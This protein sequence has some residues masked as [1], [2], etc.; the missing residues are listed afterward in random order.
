MTGLLRHA[1][2][3]LKPLEHNAQHKFAARSAL[4]HYASGA[5]YTLIPKNGCTSLRYSLALANGAIDGPEHFAWVHQNNQTFAASLADLARANYSF[6]ILR[7][8]YRRLVSAFLDKIVSKSP[9]AW[10]LRAEDSDRWEIDDFSF[11]RFIELLERPSLRLLN[12]HWR[13]QADF[14]VFEDYSDWYCLENFAEAA[15]GIEAKCGLKVHDARRLTGHG[16]DALQMLAEGSFADTTVRDL[17]QMRHQGQ[18]PAYH[19]MY[20]A[21]LRDM[22]KT[23]YAGDLGLYRAKIGADGLLFNTSK[24]QAK[25]EG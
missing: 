9:D 19:L 24:A 15:K 13:A 5:I 2:K 20:D 12:D 22:V 17:A 8:P 18:A 7:C 6:V 14:L 3:S 16:T 21:A 4:M 1:K 10:A 11:R 25:V 23:F